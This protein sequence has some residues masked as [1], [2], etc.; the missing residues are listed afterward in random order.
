MSDHWRVSALVTQL[1]NLEDV[2]LK[3]LIENWKPKKHK[4][5]KL[6]K[7]KGYN[8][9]KVNVCGIM[10]LQDIHFGKEGNDTIDADFEETVSNLISRGIAAHN[11][12]TLYFVVG[13][14]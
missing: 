1:K 11:I 13:E 3:D 12:E 7:P 6:T 9:N 4:I 8:A 2:Y 5:P 14:I 10:S